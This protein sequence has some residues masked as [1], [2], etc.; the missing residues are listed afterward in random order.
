MNRRTTAGLAVL[1]LVALGLAGCSGGDTSGA[2]KG[3]DATYAVVTHG[4]AG[5]AFWDVVK[6]GAQKAGEDL[7]VKVT[8][9]GSGKPEEQADLIN[10]AIGDKVDGIVV[11]M[12]NPDA[13]SD[14]IRKAIDADIPVITINSGQAE[15]SKLGALSHVGQDETVAGEGAGEK[16]AGAG[17]KKL[18]CVV[19]EAGNIGLEQRCSGAESTLDGKM[20]NLQVDINNIAEAQSTI[21]S[22]LQAD[23]SIDGVL[24]L[25]PAIGVAATEAV[26][27]AGSKAKVATFDLSADVINAVSQGT[28][29]F[30]V[31]Q[32]QYLQGYLPITML[33]LYRTNANTVGGGKPVLTGPGFVTKDNA[34]KVKDLAGAGTR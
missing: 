17:V 2:A 25:N 15:S 31:D 23:A 13:V 30:A 8:Y 24:A 6:K 14:P 3:G 29:L 9:Q 7:G 4:A 22:K 18:L 20:V 27:T 28:I 33:N 10:A 26:S 34:D 21:A 1:A 12:A 32:Q 19:H 11:S 5:D 16:L